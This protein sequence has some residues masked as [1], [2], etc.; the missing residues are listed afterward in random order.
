MGTLAGGQLAALRVGRIRTMLGE[1]RAS[2][3]YFHELQGGPFEY[4]ARAGGVVILTPVPLSTTKGIE[5]S[6]ASLNEK[7]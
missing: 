5:G 6:M 2:V 1:V 7:L 4:N 3:A